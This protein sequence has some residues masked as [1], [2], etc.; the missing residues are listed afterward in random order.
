MLIKKWVGK[1]DKLS[2]I[3]QDCFGEVMSKNL[4]SIQT[5]KVNI[6]YQEFLSMASK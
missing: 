2:S 3:Q 6:K 5:E 4:L 1:A